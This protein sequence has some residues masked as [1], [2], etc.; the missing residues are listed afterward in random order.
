MSLRGVASLLG[1]RVGA[2]VPWEKKRKPFASRG[3]LNLSPSVSEAT[4]AAT[5]P[6]AK[7]GSN[8]SLFSLQ[9]QE[10]DKKN[11]KTV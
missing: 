7:Q 10:K 6:P 4:E 8:A 5:P 11:R 9:E 2:R 1:R 3:K